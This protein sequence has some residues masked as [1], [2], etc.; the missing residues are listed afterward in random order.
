MIINT[1]RSGCLQKGKS[2]ASMWTSMTRSRA[3][4]CLSL[5]FGAALMMVYSSAFPS[6]RRRVRKALL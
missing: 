2:L 3:C 6:I 5:I 1:S 4:S